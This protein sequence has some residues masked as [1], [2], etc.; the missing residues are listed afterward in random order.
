MT[1]GSLLITIISED[2]R[3]VHCKQPIKRRLRKVKIST[4]RS[5]F[6][7]VCNEPET[8]YIHQ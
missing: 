6:P 7:T 4:D 2:K 5:P 3:I 8:I 1:F